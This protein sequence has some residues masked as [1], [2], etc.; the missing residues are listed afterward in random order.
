MGEGDLHR[1]QLREYAQPLEFFGQMWKPSFEDLADKINQLQGRGRCSS[2]T[3][4]GNTTTAEEMR[5]FVGVN[6]IIDKKP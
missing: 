2:L 6:I 5:A 3:R 4:N 1:N